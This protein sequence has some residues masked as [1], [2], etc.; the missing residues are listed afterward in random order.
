M[1]RTYDNHP[2]EIGSRFP[3]GPREIQQQT[4]PLR[5]TQ[6]L[7]ELSNTIVFQCSGPCFDR[8]G[9]DP[10]KLRRHAPDKPTR[11]I[12]SADRRRRS[13]ESEHAAKRRN[14][15]LFESSPCRVAEHAIET[16]LSSLTPK[17]PAEQRTVPP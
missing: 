8:T 15:C 16:V 12:D 3:L 14:T 7:F 4:C 2:Q 11:V 6:R 13:R 5:E 9:V 17:H 10:P 1:E